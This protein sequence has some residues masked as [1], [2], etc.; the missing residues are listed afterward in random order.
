M[1][2]ATLKTSAL[3][4]PWCP[5]IPRCRRPGSRPR[6]PGLCRARVG[7]EPDSV[8]EC[9]RARVLVGLTHSGVADERQASSD[10]P[11]TRS[12]LPPRDHPPTPAAGRLS[13][14]GHIGRVDS[15]GPPKKVLNPTAGE[16]IGA[17]LRRAPGMPGRRWLMPE[18]NDGWRDVPPS[19]P[20]S[21]TPSPAAR[22]GHAGARRAP[23]VQGCSSVSTLPTSSAAVLAM[24]A[25][26][27]EQLRRDGVVVGPRSDR[28]A[29]SDSRASC[30]EGVDHV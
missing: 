25:A 15:L 21:V 4:R 29:T 24:T 8:R 30:H 28:A 9:K 13:E 11:T 10:R 27:I 12:R 17:V 6:S 22:T 18:C 1:V 26:A 23:A 5:R 19:E 20:S 14:G 3:T 7:I 2:S 16:R